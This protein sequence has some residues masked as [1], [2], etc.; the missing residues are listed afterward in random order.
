MPD[1]ADDLGVD[2]ETLAD[3]YRTDAARQAAEVHRGR[4][5]AQ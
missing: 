3:A 1:H 5:G 4:I 2:D